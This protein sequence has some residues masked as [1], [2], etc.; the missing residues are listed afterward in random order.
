MLFASKS[1]EHIYRMQVDTDFSKFA[2]SKTIAAFL[3]PSWGEK[4]LIRRNLF[5][6][7]LLTLLEEKK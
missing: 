7:T 2:S 4:K 5:C 6:Q 3:P 1:K